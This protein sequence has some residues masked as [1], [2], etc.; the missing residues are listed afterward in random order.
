VEDFVGAKFYCPYALADGNQYIRI[1]AKT[2]VFSSTVLSTQSP[3]LYCNYY[4]ELQRLINLD[5]V[6]NHRESNVDGDENAS[7][8]NTGAT[9]DKHRTAAMMNSPHQ[10]TILSAQHAHI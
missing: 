5:I 3:C 8:S 10:S 2:L 1:R 4:K 7:S 6:F 9:V